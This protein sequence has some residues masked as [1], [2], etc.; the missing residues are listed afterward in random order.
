[1]SYLTQEMLIDNTIIAFF[2]FCKEKR[3]KN[4]NTTKYKR[5]SVQRF[6]I[7]RKATS[8]SRNVDPEGQIGVK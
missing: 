2:T 6:H 8:V 3:C 4:T 1:M 5:K 7:R